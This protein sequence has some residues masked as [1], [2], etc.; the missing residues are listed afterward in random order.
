M[1][2]R[3]FERKPPVCC[4]FCTHILRLCYL[5]M[6]VIDET[7]YLPF[8]VHFASVSHDYEYIK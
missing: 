7:V 3:L 2:P 1:H 4:F 5:K 6:F 8:L